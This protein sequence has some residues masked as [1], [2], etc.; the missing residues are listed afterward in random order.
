ML[1]FNLANY[2]HSLNYKLWELRLFDSLLMKVRVWKRLAYRILTL[3]NFDVLTVILGSSRRC[4]LSLRLCNHVVRN[5]LFGNA[6]V[7]KHACSL[8]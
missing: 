5:G 3:S 7:G 2:I 1:H 6:V 4:S 8:T